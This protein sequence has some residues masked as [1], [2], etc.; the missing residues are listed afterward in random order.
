MSQKDILL[1]AMRVPLMVS[2]LRSTRARV[3]AV[4]GG[5]A[6]QQEL[7]DAVV[8]VLD[9][10]LSSAIGWRRRE[11]RLVTLEAEVALHVDDDSVVLTAVDHFSWTEETLRGRGPDAREWMVVSGFADRV[12][13]TEDS[14]AT[15]TAVFRR[16]P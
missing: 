14:P 12:T 1:Y 10:A 8:W 11:N 15:F 16:T 9:T 5:F 2:V 13:L 7:S 6:V 4:L 3:R